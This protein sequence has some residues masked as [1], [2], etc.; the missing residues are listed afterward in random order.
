MGLKG[1]QQKILGSESFTRWLIGGE[2]IHLIH[3]LKANLSELP[4]KKFCPIKSS[5]KGL[6][7]CYDGCTWPTSI[8]HKAMKS[9]LTLSVLDPAETHPLHTAMIHSQRFHKVHFLN[10]YLIENWVYIKF[11]KCE[12][13]IIS[14]KS[15]QLVFVGPQYSPIIH[16]SPSP[17]NNFWSICFQLQ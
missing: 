12:H 7:L 4:L 16:M 5:Q 1:P 9:Q 14:S 6:L 8:C 3:T 17:Q 15:F 13:T 2:V 11:L 10:M